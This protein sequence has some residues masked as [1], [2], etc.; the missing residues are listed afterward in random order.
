MVNYFISQSISQSI[1]Q[2]INEFSIQEPVNHSI[3]HGWLFGAHQTFTLHN[4][5]GTQTCNASQKVH[6]PCHSLH[7]LNCM[8]HRSSTC[9]KIHQNAH[10][11]WTQ[12]QVR[13]ADSSSI[14]TFKLYSTKHILH[15]MSHVVEH[16]LA[17]AETIS[18]QSICRETN[19]VI[20]EQKQKVI[21][22]TSRNISAN[23]YTCITAVRCQSKTRRSWAPRT[24][25]DQNLPA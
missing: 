8:D 16:I 21:H 1:N 12:H 19:Y 14:Y 20:I 9:Q 22:S 10:F 7:D 25:K 2:S 23:T 13:D 18:D 11:R 3:S 5:T 4:C 24:Q 17:S 6:L 15:P